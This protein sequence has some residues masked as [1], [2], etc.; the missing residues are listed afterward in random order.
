MVA[1]GEGARNSVEAAIQS[2]GS[3]L[4]VVVP[5]NIS[6][7]KQKTA[8]LD[9]KD[10]RAIQ[11]VP[12]IKSIAPEIS[13]TKQVSSG[14]ESVTSLVSGVEP[15]FQV[16][17]NVQIDL[18]QF[19][20]DQNVKN[21]SKVAVIGPQV[22]RVFFGNTPGIGKTIRIGYGN[23]KVIGITKSKGGNS[24]GNQDAQI[25]IPITSAKELLSG[26]DNFSA[27]SIE[28]ADKDKLDSV[29]KNITTSLFKLHNISDH[30]QADFTVLN[31]ADVISAA[32]SIANTFTV[33][34]ASIAGISLI[35][36]GVGIM[37]MMLVNVKDRTKEIGLRKA[38]GA[39]NRDI[40][41]QFLSEAVILTSIGGIMGIILGYIFSFFIKRFAGV[42]TEIS[43][44]AVIV[45]FVVSAG[46]GV[47]FGY[48]PARKAANLSP[49][50][51]LR[52]E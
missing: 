44:I 7:T 29:Q 5:G 36:G 31:Q 40:Y 8:S 37:N 49:I 26:R 19:I 13:M 48:Y 33:L 42:N 30:N 4:L 52:Y 17:R 25:F 24:S 15:P 11:N 14:S 12:D 41:M 1:I 34:L 18:G 3:N 35:V 16:V 51:A 2:V 6:N 46:I 32:G 38:I 43:S 45:I 10:L 9:N 20:T 39:R 50:E 21:F 22:Q 23:F 28:V 27:I 47:I